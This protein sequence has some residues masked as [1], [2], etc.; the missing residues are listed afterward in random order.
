MTK[1]GWM[2]GPRLS[3][4]SLCAQVIERLYATSRLLNDAGRYAYYGQVGGRP[5]SDN[6]D[7]AKHGATNILYS[8]QRF[9]YTIP[10]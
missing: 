6:A 5:L 9:G 2:D 10:P 3:K 8:L 7:G 4:S 1:H